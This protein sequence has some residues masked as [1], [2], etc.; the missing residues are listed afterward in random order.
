MAHNI[1]K[2]AA[3][4]LA[5]AAVIAVPASAN[6]PSETV[7]AAPD[8]Y[9]DDWLHVND[10]AEIVDMNGNP[11]WMTGVNWFGYNVGSQI[12]DGAWSANV[13]HCLDLIADHGFNLLRV[14]MSTEILLQWKNGDP[15]PIIK[16]NEYENPELTIEGVEGG[17]PMYSFDIWNQVVKWCRENGIK[18]MM[19]IHSATTNAAGHNYALWYDSNFST[20]DWLEALAWFADYYK[21]DDTVIAIDLK[22][23]PHGKT[24]DGIYAKWDGSTDENNWRYAAERGAKACLDQNPNLLI[25]VEGIEVYP[26]FEEGES[27]AS[28]SVDY[29]RYPWSPYH[30]AWWGANFRGVREF[31]VDL[32][33]HQSQ[34]VY[35]PHDYG[36]EVYKQTWVYLE[37][38]SK[39]FSRETLL[40]DYWRDTW[41]FLVEENISPI[42]MGEW[43][44]WV[45]DEHDK[46]GENRHWLQEIRDYMIDKH[47]HHTFWCFNENSSDTGGLVYDNFQKW[48]DIKYE[49]IKPAL[50]QTEDGKFI[51]LD[52]KIPMGRAGNGISLDEYYSGNPG[53]Q[54]TTQTTAAPDGTTTTSVTTGTTTSSTKDTTATSK[55]TT[56]TTATTSKSETT[57]TS[58]SSID[59]NGDTLYGDANCDKEVSV[60]DAV[61][62]MQKIANPSKYDVNGTD[63]KHITAQGIVNS[64]CFNNGDGVTNKDALAIQQYKLGLIKELPA[65]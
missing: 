13:H 58:T 1:F 60:A 32:G 20:D 56:T 26:K 4:M 55:E 15:D 9:H 40:D 17:T 6:M 7:I 33:E 30:G 16:L 62:I 12:F 51:S 43:G 3:A 65:K 64:D 50:W 52:H 35:S 36:P 42:L 63:E 54:S 11:V 45:D 18:I 31:P 46:T 24:D 53:S 61:L 19:D 2:R 49:F 21:D 8:E 59:S 28:H 10:K 44:G 41:A 25:M 27:W 39:T 14:P 48:D 23:E 5:A 29:A 37:D 47:I 34:L 22:N 38:E 57:T